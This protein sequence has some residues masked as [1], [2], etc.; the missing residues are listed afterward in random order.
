MS[1]GRW[2]AFYDAAPR[3]SVEGGVV[4][5]KP[6]KVSDP[7]SQD[8]V[9]AAEMESQPQILAR[10]RTYA[11][12]GQ[13]VSLQVEPESFS[14]Q[15][16]GTGSKPYDVRL[17]RTTISGS[18]RVAASCTCPYGCD[19]GWCK[20]AAALAYVAAFLLDH[21]PVARSTWSVAVATRT[22]HGGPDDF[23]DSGIPK[24]IADT[25][26][27]PASALMLHAEDLATLR[28]PIPT[29]DPTALLAAAEMLVPHPWHRAIPGHAAVAS[30]SAA[31]PE[32]PPTVTA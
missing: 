17:D 7:V 24:T 28:R 18:D 23:E 8:L 30:E 15:I 4:V 5:A 26:V 3:R 19:F 20:H 16:Q 6:G 11:R 2:G 12:A 25:A 22:P 31:A 1:R 27:L 13:V 9:A 29:L 21:D 14:A 32:T 10:G